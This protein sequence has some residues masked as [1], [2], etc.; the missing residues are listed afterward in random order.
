MSRKYDFILFPPNDTRP[1]RLW[2]RVCNVRHVCDEATSL[3]FLSLHSLQ[4]DPLP[5]PH[6]YAVAG[7]LRGKASPICMNIISFLIKWTV[8]SEV[9]RWNITLCSHTKYDIIALLMAIFYSA[10]SQEASFPNRRSLKGR[11]KVFQISTFSVC[12]CR[13]FSLARIAR[14]HSCQQ[15][16][17]S[18]DVEYVRNDKNTKLA[19]V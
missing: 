10:G 18:E 17:S 5:F 9:M 19:V 3:T 4:N 2:S 6:C 8:M 12:W 13:L 11:T 16:K 7:N 14:C 1:L 15:H